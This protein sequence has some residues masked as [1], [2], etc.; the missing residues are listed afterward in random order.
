MSRYPYTAAADVAG[1]RFVKAGGA[2]GTIIQATGSTDALLGVSASM[3]GKS[4]QVVDV[5]ETG[6]AEIEY[7]GAVAVG[8][9]LTSDAVGRAVK[10]NPGA[11]VVAQV[12]GY[13][14]VAG[15]LGD[16]GSMKTARGQIKG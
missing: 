8:D 3:G 14:R 11:G 5:E 15:V 2:A 16:F 12:G 7:G 4:G 9:P 6:V 1:R 13:A 10:A